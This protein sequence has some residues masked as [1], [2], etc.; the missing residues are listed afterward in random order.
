MVSAQC[1]PSWVGTWLAIRHVPFVTQH[2][3]VQDI[4]ASD[5]MTPRSAQWCLGDESLHSNDFRGQMAKTIGSDYMP[6]S[7][8]QRSL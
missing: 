7:S 4:I 5:T 6:F 2:N 1:K 3:G 8:K